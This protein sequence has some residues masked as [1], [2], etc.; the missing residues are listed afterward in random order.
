M[1]APIKGFSKHIWGR[2]FCDVAESLGIPLKNIHD[3]PLW[4]APNLDGSFSERYVSGCET[5]KWFKMVLAEKGCSDLE[6][7]TPHGAKATLLSMAAK[8]G[9]GEED[10]CVL[11]DH[12]YRRSSAA[13]YSR[14]LH[15]APLRRLE[16][17]LACVRNGTFMP[18]ASRSGMVVS[19]AAEPSAMSKSDHN[20]GVAFGFVEG[21]SY[22]GDF[23]C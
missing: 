17:M 5:S 23:E 10:R 6:S 21:E 12:A 16:R 22:Q 19:S 8:F 2:L 11:A 4:R 20:K 9:L 1:V 18:D 7:L 15:A 13:T 3:Q 14:D